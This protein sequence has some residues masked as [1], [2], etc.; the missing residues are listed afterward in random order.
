MSNNLKKSELQL[1]YPY[2]GKIET[3]PF[4]ATEQTQ[5]KELLLQLPPLIKKEWNERTTSDPE[6]GFSGLR[7]FIS[8]EKNLEEVSELLASRAPTSLG[9]ALSL[10]SLLLRGLRNNTRVLKCLSTHAPYLQVQAPDTITIA[11]RTLASIT[12]KEIQN[13]YPKPYSALQVFRT[14]GNFTKVDI[15][16]N[17]RSR[18]CPSEREASPSS[19]VRDKL[20]NKA[21]IVPFRIHLALS[22]GVT[23]GPRYMIMDQF[24]LNQLRRAKSWF[25]IDAVSE[26]PDD[27]DFFRIKTLTCKLLRVYERADAYASDS[28]ISSSAKGSLL[29]PILNDIFSDRARF[30]DDQVTRENEVE[31]ESDDESEDDSDDELDKYDRCVEQG[32][33]AGPGRKRNNE[34]GDPHLEDYFVF[35]VKEDQAGFT[36]TLKSPSKTEK[37]VHI[38]FRPDSMIVFHGVPVI[39][40]EIDSNNSSADHFRMIGQ[41][42]GINRLLNIQ[43]DGGYR[44][45]PFIKV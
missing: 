38:T 9:V 25:K 15:K 32:K 10:H 43:I 4:Q 27:L 28:T 21:S 29:L 30:Q 34:G 17:L 3:V 42:C 23:S 36:F 7:L 12:T 35:R 39:F 19:L 41:A 24:H 44:P 33:A 18:G 8:P 13:L 5:F 22:R 40:C 1:I 14:E 37:L 6:P 16:E 20:W 2:R 26:E 45:Y 31:V 11:F